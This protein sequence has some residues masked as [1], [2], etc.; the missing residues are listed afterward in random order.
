MKITLLNPSSKKRKAAKKMARKKRKVRKRKSP[1]RKSYKRSTPKRKY[2]TRRNPMRKRRYRRNPTVG[3]KLNFNNILKQIQPIALGALGG[4][5]LNMG[6]NRFLTM[7]N[8]NAKP[9]V[10]LAIAAALPLLVRKGQLGQIAKYGSIVTGAAAV[11]ELVQQFMP[12]LELDGDGEYFA[13]QLM[14]SENVEF[15]GYDPAYNISF[16]PDSSVLGSE[17]IEF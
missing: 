16:D 5:G 6:L 2:S 11:K 4:I 3:G 9:W 15:A 8:E 14:G 17:N 13:P 10:K 12:E 7:E 1:A